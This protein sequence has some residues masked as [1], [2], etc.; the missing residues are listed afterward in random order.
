MYNDI[1]YGRHKNSPESVAANE[2]LERSGK[3]TRQRAKVL[4]E[5]KASGMYGLT[6][7]ELAQKWNIGQNNISGRFSE[8]KGIKGKMPSL[9][10]KIGVRDRSGIYVARSNA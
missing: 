3:K 4:E 5:I 1:T 6:C 2:R 9:I 8:L 7:R 10:T